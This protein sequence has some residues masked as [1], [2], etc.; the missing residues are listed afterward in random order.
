MNR[1][2]FTL[3]ELL[4]TLVILGIVVSIGGVAITKTISN[5]KQKNYDTLVAN[6]KSAVE[7]YYQECQYGRIQ[8][9]DYSYCKTNNDDT[10]YII[11]ASVLLAHGYIN[12][13]ADNMLINPKDEEKKVCKIKYKYNSSAYKIEVTEI[14]EAAKTAT[15]C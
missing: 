5:S 13:N 14:V 12:P 15:G 6:I 2:G 9:Q 7:E 4:A 8:G 3:V 1:K 11:G 10:V